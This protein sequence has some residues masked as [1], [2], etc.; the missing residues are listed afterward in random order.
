MALASTVA[1]LHMVL[2]MS[3]S[4]SSSPSTESSSPRRRG[5][6][7]HWSSSK[8][9]IFDGLTGGGVG[10]FDEYDLM[11]R[12]AASSDAIL[13]LP[14]DERPPLPPYGIEDALRESRMWD[15]TFAIVVYDPPHDKFIGLYSKS[16]QW[17]Q[18]N[19]K[20]FHA[21]RHL[22]HAV[23]RLF[24]GRFAGPGSPEMVFAIGGGDY[25][26]VKRSEL[27]RAT[28]GGGVAP[29]LMFGSAFRN[30][31]VYPNMMPMP[32][33][34][35]QH[36]DCFTHWI[37]AGTVCKFWRERTHFASSDLEVKEGGDAGANRRHGSDGKLIFGEGLGLQW[38]DLKPQLVWRGSDFNFLP[39]LCRAVRPSTGI[40]HASPR[41]GWGRR[42]HGAIRALAREYDTLLPRWKAAVL[43]AQAEEE[44]DE[45]MGR[46]PWANM[47]FSAYMQGGNKGPTAGSPI[48]A[49]WELAGIAV[50]RGISPLELARY[51]YHI[52]LGGGGGTTWTGTTNKLAMPGLLFH[53]VTPTK[54]YYHDLMVPW[55]H[56]VP[57][58]HDLADLR[59]KFDWAE[60]RP[61][62]ARKIAESA[63]QFMR[64]LGTPEGFG[65]M[66]EASF[67]DPIRRAIDAYQ[68]VS[69]TH[70]GGATWREVLSS[71]EDGDRF[72]P[73]MECTG[74]TCW[75]ARARWTEGDDLRGVSGK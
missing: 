14:G 28:D 37:D 68:P 40:V 60:S 74:V 44:A 27:P 45:R 15:Y 49:P 65:R 21:M 9:S 39:S 64:Y 47:K 1:A 23:R 56:Y 61:G 16:H 73:V 69:A 54:D 59:S 42:R 50:G 53:H 67:V 20:L 34:T 22:C 51:R 62:E 75:E 32:M 4:P 8:F 31:E 72:V 18:S 13:N 5:L 11:A 63:T 19:A 70:P 57:V 30:G 2:F 25:P 52:D 36:L 46:E 17:K 6:K 10:S 7:N 33:P 12:E 71:L 24:P 38:D 26:H 29:V 66:F 48:Y 3:P 58:N 41:I 35:P 43:T 55:R